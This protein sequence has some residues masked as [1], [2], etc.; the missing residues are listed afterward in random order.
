MVFEF[1]FCFLDFNRNKYNTLQEIF[2]CVLHY[3]QGKTPK[4]SWRP[5]DQGGNG[6]SNILGNV[7]RVLETFWKLCKIPE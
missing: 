1:F 6:T 2:E 4:A 7:Q 5:I 3:L